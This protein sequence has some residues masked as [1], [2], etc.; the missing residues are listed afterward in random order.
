[1]SSDQELDIPQTVQLLSCLSEDV[2]PDYT[3][4]TI[5]DSQQ[6]YL[7]RRLNSVVPPLLDAF[8]FFLR[9]CPRDGKVF[10]MTLSIGSHEVI[11]ALAANTTEDVNRS[12][13]SSPGVILSTIW[14]YMTKMA[15]A[16]QK[17]AVG[18]AAYLLNRNSTLLS[19]RFR[20]RSEVY[21]KFRRTYDQIRKSP[22]PY[23]DG[24]RDYLER[25][26][27]I[28]TTTKAFVEL[29]DSSKGRIAD[30][31]ITK[32]V[33]TL[34]SEAAGLEQPN[35]GVIAGIEKM[36]GIDRKS[37]TLM[38]TKPTLTL[39]KDYEFDLIHYANK[40]CSPIVHLATFVR[41][42]S[43][44]RFCD[45]LKL[46]FRIHIVPNPTTA[47]NKQTLS[48]AW[49]DEA[50]VAAFIREAYT[51]FFNGN[52]AVEKIITTLARNTVQQLREDD[53]RDV[54]GPHCE[55]LLIQY[56]HNNPHLLTHPYIAVSKPCCL[57]CSIF[58]DAYNDY[59]D[60]LDRV[61]FSIKARS[62]RVYP[63][64]LPTL[65]EADASIVNHMRSSIKRVVC[66]IVTNRLSEQAKVEDK[67]RIARA[68]AW[69][70]Q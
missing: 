69:F 57:Q 25:V 55:C 70:Q 62:N 64:V 58:L 37:M 24:V 23:I 66:T 20:K 22:N 16:D 50:T 1:M 41:V 68:L 48:Q 8:N 51:S 35:I 33:H 12:D 6:R 44:S 38:L 31:S 59:A 52:A 15:T 60:R 29:L 14:D 21:E 56:H 34:M 9:T 46:N 13:A 36:A 19:H 65:A 39:P 17:T 61:A 5:P 11:A 3:P 42:S 45:L 7:D 43:S 4:G 10:A 47:V 2:S 67:A 63:C 28:Y 26:H 27:V 49:H 30:E 53:T 18:C 54:S 32:F 40:L